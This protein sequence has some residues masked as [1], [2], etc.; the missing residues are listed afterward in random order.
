MKSYTTSRNLYGT[1]TQNT[2]ASNLTLGDQLMNDSIRHI[3]T[4]SYNWGFLETSTTAL[5]VAS[6]DT[7]E[8][9]YNLDKLRAVTV[10]AGTTKWSLKEITSRAQWSNLKQEPFSSDVPQYYYIESG[11]LEMYPTP[12][13]SGNTITYFYK[14]AVKDL[15][16]ADYT[17]GTAST[18]TATQVVTGSGTTFTAGMVGR[19]FKYDDN[20]FWYKI[21]SFTSTT[22][23]GLEKVYGGSTVSGESFTIGELSI[24]P[25]AYQDLPVYRAVAMYYKTKGEQVKSDMF[26]NDYLSGVERLIADHGSK[27]TNVSL[28]DSSGEINPNLYVSF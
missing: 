5:T 18:T 8:L 27:T 2:E 22:V 9:P 15:S 12:S 24:L 3:L 1:L 11:N 16:A 14:Q 26:M 10:T 21:T 4:L 25:E 6:T 7:Y 13:S 23:I 20:G 19:W 28:G 17:T